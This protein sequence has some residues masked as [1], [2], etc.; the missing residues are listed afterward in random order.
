MRRVRPIGPSKRI[1]AVV[2]L[3]EVS[4]VPT[5]V[6]RLGFG[7]EHLVAAKHRGQFEANLFW[8]QIFAIKESPNLVVHG[9]GDLAGHLPF[10]AG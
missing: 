10:P 6:F 4:G 2:I 3:N 8:C 1:S 5:G 7:G 9:G